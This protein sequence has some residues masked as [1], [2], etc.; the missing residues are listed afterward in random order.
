LLLIAL[1]PLSACALLPEE[2]ELPRA[3]LV[4]VEEIESYSQVLVER[5]DMEL[6]RKVN[7][8][9]LPVLTEILRFE[10]GGEYFDKALVEVGDTVEAGD[11]IIQLRLDDILQ[12]IANAES[13]LT[14]LRLSVTQLEE[15]RILA[16]E[17]VRIATQYLSG[18]AQSEAT[19]QVARQYDDQRRAL[20]DAIY[21]Q[22]K[23]V[24]ELAVEY[25]KRQLRAGIDGTVTYIRKINEGDMSAAGDRVASIADSTT[26]ALRTETDLWEH[27]Q[28]GDLFIMIIDREEY[29][30]VVV[31]EESLGLP[32]T[33]PNANNKNYVYMALVQ[34]MFLDDGARGTVTVILDSRTDVLKLPTKAVT[35]ANGEKIVYFQDE[36]GMKNIKRVETGLVADGMVEIVSGLSD[37]DSVILQ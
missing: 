29:E 34:P 26:S 20:E 14:S 3:P 33:E 24:D 32:R 28:V 9:Y 30:A 16:L 4:K 25:D 37:G 13:Q 5:G 27:M 17:R 19:R 12:K 22:Q 15:N 18:A 10:V 23:K 2:E 1:L 8:T 21:I 35:S 36:E 7:F 11:P 31:D 6:T